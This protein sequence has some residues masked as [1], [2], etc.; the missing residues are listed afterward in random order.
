MDSAA[1]QVEDMFAM[2]DYIDAQFGGPGAGFLRIVT[3]PDEAR[4][5]INDGKLAMVLGIEISEL[6]DCGTDDGEALCDEEQIDAGLDEL[7]DLGIRTVF[8]VHKFDNALGGTAYDGGLTGILVNAG[9]QHVT[10]EWWHPEPCGTDAIPDNTVLSPAG[11][12]ESVAEPVSELFDVNVDDL[13]ASDPPDYGDGPHCNPLGLTDLGRHTIDGLADRGMI[14]ETDHLSALARQ[15]AL[16]LLAE[17]G[18]PG[19]ISSHSWGDEITQVQLQEMGGMVAPY[20]SS[21]PAFVDRWRTTK[22]SAPEEFHFGIGFGTDTNGLGAQPNP[23]ADNESDPVV[24]PYTTF[25]GGTEMARSRS[26]TKTF[27]INTDGAAHYGMFPD[28]IEDMRSI[29]GDEIVDDLAQ[30]PEAYLQ[31][32]QRALDNV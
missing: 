23:R 24:Y 4:R 7:Y 6:A 8:P 26:G 27:D 21:L 10:G 30:G 32:W 5:V 15:E 12:F 13:V 3:S 25:D 29:A 11:V 19:V 31:M 17:R 28:W 2:Q 16:D 20:A 18:Y 1:Q 9:N 22:E 14:V